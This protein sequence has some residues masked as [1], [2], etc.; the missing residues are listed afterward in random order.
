MCKQRCS[1]KREGMGGVGREREKSSGGEHKHS[2]LVG[3][4][5]ITNQTTSW[6]ISLKSLNMNGDWVCA[7]TWMESN[8]IASWG[9]GN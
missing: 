3:G 6:S 5:N 2:S 9:L 1:L 8:E 7:D 4:V